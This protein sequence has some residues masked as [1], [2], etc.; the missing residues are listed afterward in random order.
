MKKMRFVLKS[1][2]LL[3]LAAAAVAVFG[4]TGGA[5]GQLRAGAARVDITGPLAPGMDPPTGKYEHEH[6]YVRAILVDNGKDRA[7]LIGA[8]QGGLSDGVWETASKKISQEIGCPVA[9]ILMSAT[10]SHSAGAGGPGPSQGA[11]LSP[12]EQ[13]VADAM[14]QAVQEAKGKLQPVEMAFGTGQAYLNV[15]RDTINPDTH[16]WTQGPN[17]NAPSDKTVAVL[18]FE[19]PQHKPVALYVNYA[20]HPINGYLAN[21]TSADFAGAMS[22]YVEKDYGDQAVAIFSQGASGDQNPLYMHASTDGLASRSGVEITGEELEREHVEQPLREGP[23]KGKPMDPAVR[24]RLE[25][26]MQTEGEVLGEEVIRVMT[27][28]KPVQGDVRIWA[29][30]VDVSCPGRDRI[31]KGREGMEGEYKDSTAVPLRLGV[32][33]IGDVALTHIDAEVYT[34]IGQRLKRQSPLTNTVF[35]TLANGRAPSG[36][37]PDDASY[38]HKTFQVLGA[39]IKQGCAEDTISNTL[40]QLVTEYDT[41]QP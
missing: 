24:D 29:K 26:W 1:S 30:Q 39:R 19:T 2:I 7:V 20:M 34:M 16:K 10:H 6:L 27:H 25:N 28:S 9:N 15:N 21:F 38:G 35:V 13:R 37:I 17:L 40:A 12:A 11:G 32:I 36:Y 14:V 23:V 18:A 33:A 31:D 41:K 8:D 3:Q 4:L 22:R 5:S